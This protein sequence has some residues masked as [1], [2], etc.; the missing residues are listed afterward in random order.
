MRSARVDSGSTLKEVIDRLFRVENDDVAP[1]RGE[2][3]NI[4]Y[5]LYQSLSNQS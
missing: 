1:E 5:S 4:P 2:M 3:H